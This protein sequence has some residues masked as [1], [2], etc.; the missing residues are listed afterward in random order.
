MHLSFGM[1][2]VNIWNDLPQHLRDLVLISGALRAFDAT[3]S[4]RDINILKSENNNITS[5]R[6]FRGTIERD[7]VATAV[8]FRSLILRF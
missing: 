3:I 7:R 2:S 5:V 4:H 6:R 8:T 1:L